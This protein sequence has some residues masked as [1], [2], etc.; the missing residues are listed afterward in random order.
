MLITHSKFPSTSLGYAIVKGQETHSASKVKGLVNEQSPLLAHGCTRSCLPERSHD[1]E[2]ASCEDE[3]STRY[4]VA[5]FGSVFIGVFLAALDTTIVATLSV[6]ISNTFGSLTLVSWLGSSYLIANAA[7]QPLSGRLTDIFS[8][9]SGLVVCNLLFGV[10]T[11]MCG[12]A[13][14][15]WIL[16][17]GRVVAGMGGGGLN[18][19]TAFVASDLVPLRKRGVV[20]GFVHICYGVGAGLGGLFGGWINDLWGW[21]TAFLCRVPLIA[22]S[23][24]L[25]SIT[26]KNNPSKPSHK[27]R[28]SRVDFSGAFTLSLTLI[29]LLLGLNSGGNL[30]AWSH[31]LVL[32]SVSL[33][34]VAA[35]SFVLVESK[36][37]EEPIIP[38]HLLFDQTVLSAC[39]MN[40]LVTMVLFMATYYVPVFFQVNGFSTTAAG[41]RL[42]PQSVG[43]ALSSLT[44]GFIMKRTGRYRLLG[45][46]VI[47]CSALGFLGLSTMVIETPTPLVLL[48]VFL[49]GVGYGGM[50]SVTL[51]ATVAAVSHE[52]QAVATSANYAFRS[53]GSTIGVTIA[54]VV[55]QYL[56]QHGLRHRFGSYEGS[57]EVIKR[58]LDSLDELKHLPDGWT[59]GVFEAY[60]I[61]L[62]GVFLSGLG[63]SVWG[64]IAASF[65]KE[66]RLHNTISRAD[67]D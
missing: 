21:R 32:V 55:Y 60:E 12:I 61:A 6:P 66:H 15:K 42:V 29:L 56:L 36:W 18:A 53:M 33:S 10:G 47:A 34:V 49:V 50:L 24:I 11:C 58:L 51:L 27:S 62:R 22:I 35:G 48:F 65:I 45:M 9:R 44:C 23:T 20:Q 54:S 7:C 59:K 3:P 31:P 8:R 38:M 39:L 1:D 16:L 57:A 17:A 4:L 13:T 40:W 43:T 63:V 41:L 25:V 64:L 67:E 30:V 28:L 14:S 46:A 37:A 26:L 19:I 5:V 52:E 2:S